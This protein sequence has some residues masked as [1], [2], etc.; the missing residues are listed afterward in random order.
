MSYPTPGR[1]I[2][3]C[4]EYSLVGV[5]TSWPTHWLVPLVRLLIVWKDVT[6]IHVFNFLIGPWLDLCHKPIRRC[7]KCV[8]MSQ[9]YP[10]ATAHPYI[11]WP[12]HPLDV[13]VAS[14]WVRGTTET[15]N[16]QS[17]SI[18]HICSPLKIRCCC[19]RKL[20]FLWFVCCSPLNLYVS[21]LADWSRTIKSTK[22][23]PANPRW[24]MR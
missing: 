3:L 15:S 19:K 5:W 4:E 13:V 9:W 24:R 6:M 11:M 10:D 14:S 23:I 17:A 22:D 2:S 20:A 18:N 7:K 1:G 21:S 12:R 16:P 8:Q